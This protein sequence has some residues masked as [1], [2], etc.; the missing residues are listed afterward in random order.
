MS[1]I[2]QTEDF[3]VSAHD[4]PHHSRENGG[5]IVITPKQKFAHRYEM[6]LDLAS[7]LMH[8]TMIVGEAA[9][10][11][12]RARG[13]EVVRINYQD[14]GNWAYKHPNPQ[15]QLHKHLYIRTANEKH[16]TNDPRFQSFPDA[17]VFP[18]PD[19]D[20]Y[21][22]FAPLNDEDCAAIK[23]DYDR[24]LATDKYSGVV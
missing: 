21:D 18:D 10:N 3:V 17:L 16:P 13:L 11:A 19:T 8:M 15:P 1:V 20:Y 5:H 22:Q 14:N 6:P 12:L 7:K 9:T 23:Q 2:V 24:L 4:K